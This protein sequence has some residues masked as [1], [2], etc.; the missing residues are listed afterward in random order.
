MLTMRILFSS[1]GSTG[2][3]VPFLNLGQSLASEGVA[4]RLST[5]EHFRRKVDK[6]PLEFWASSDR[7]LGLSNQ[8]QSNDGVVSWMRNL[9]EVKEQA[10]QA[11]F[12]C[13]D[14]AWEASQG[15]D[16]FLFHPKI[17]I[18]EDILRARK[19]PGAM[20]AFAPLFCPTREFSHPFFP[21]LPFVPGYN[22]LSYHLAALQVAAVSSWIEEW[23]T[24]RLGIRERLAWRQLMD[25]MTGKSVKT[26]HAYSQHVVPRPADWPEG[27]IVDRYWMPPLDCS[28]NPNDRVVEFFKRGEPPVYVG[29]GSMV[30]EQSEVLAESI[31][32]AV[33]ELGLRVV[34]ASGWGG[35]GEVFKGQPDVIVEEEIPHSWVFP[36]VKAVIHHGG[37]GTTSAACHA[38]TPQILCP[39]FGDQQFWAMR[40]RDLGVSG[41]TIPI[42]R[43][44]KSS[45]QKALKAAIGDP[46]I[47]KSAQRL[48]E[49][50]HQE[51]SAKTGSVH[52]R[53]TQ[54]LRGAGPA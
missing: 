9:R 16:A 48:A 44:N 35:I 5:H 1:A 13:W 3:I 39:F 15:V 42:S 34:F 36:R 33:R 41:G 20:V 11:L 28:Q 29:F 54:F 51:R 45:L 25:R 26:I 30:S 52:Q 32:E 31:L 46:S 22:R 47:L 53:L 21:P 2:D 8:P 38:G 27:A 37:A 49:Q 6:L 10:K 40:A 17:L 12:D 4:V 14:V 7:M 19:I 23:R 43:L 18:G 24:L 50:L